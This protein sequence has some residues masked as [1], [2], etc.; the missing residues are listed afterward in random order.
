[1]S[2]TDKIVKRIILKA[3]QEKVW[4]AISDSKRFGTWFGVEF[5]EPFEEG[6]VMI[7]KMTPTKVDPEVAKMQAPFTGKKFEFVIDKI[8]PMRYFS[9]HW[10]PFAV[11]ASK[12]YSTEPKTLVSFELEQNTEGTHL[13][14]TESGFDQIPLERRAEAF[15]ANDGGWSKQISMVN[16]Y[17]MDFMDK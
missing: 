5:N 14:I 10:H 17:V 16:T 2:E 12:D 13:T 11:D 15:T 9:F 6:K 4:S 7:G 8:E 3:P 1:M